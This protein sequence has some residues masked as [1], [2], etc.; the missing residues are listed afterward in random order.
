MA[1]QWDLVKDMNHDGM[2]TISDVWEWFH[3]IFFYFGDTVIYWALT[4]P[5][6]DVT[7]FFEITS[8]SYGGFWSGVISVTTIIFLIWVIPTTY[9]GICAWA[10]EWKDAW[11]NNNK[12][13]R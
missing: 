3:G 8:S 9:K 10:S 11:Q 7:N 6:K 13:G 2:F 4:S 12:T 1:R 5:R